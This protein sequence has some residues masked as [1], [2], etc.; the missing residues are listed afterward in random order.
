M[1][2]TVTPAAPL[3]PAVKCYRLL[4][5][6]GAPFDNVTAGSQTFSRWTEQITFD[7]GDG[8]TIRDRVRGALTPLYPDEVARVR[9]ALDKMRVRWLQREANRAIV[10]EPSVTFRERPGDLPLSEFVSMEECA[11]PDAPPPS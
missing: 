4:V 3:A 1:P 10:F 11:P 7:P 5:L 6:E 2:E 8:S 9:A